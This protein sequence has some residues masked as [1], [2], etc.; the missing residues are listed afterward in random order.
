MRAS[1]LARRRLEDVDDDG[2][3]GTFGEPNFFVAEQNW[4]RSIRDGD[5]LN[6]LGCP[7]GR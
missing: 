5:P 7:G 3:G 4:P 1:P 6:A 2:R